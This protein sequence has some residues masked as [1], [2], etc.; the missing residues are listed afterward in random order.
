[1]AFKICV[2]EISSQLVV[3]TAAFGFNSWICFT[4]NSNCSWVAFWLR[5]KITVVA[6]SIWLLKNSPKFFRYVLHFFASTT[7]TALFKWTPSSAVAPS[8]ARMTSDNLPTPEGSI[9][10]RSGWYWFNTS[11]N[12]VPKSPTKEQQIHPEFISVILIPASFKN[13]PSI[14]ISPN[15]FS[16]NTTCSPFNASFSIFLISVVFPAPKKPDTI[17]IFVAIYIT[18]PLKQWRF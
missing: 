2:P 3:I 13:P 16:I 7:A 5:L 14:P 18:F 6:Y 15:S 1:M 12:A 11:F 10:I 8:T 17:S 4:Q 9:K